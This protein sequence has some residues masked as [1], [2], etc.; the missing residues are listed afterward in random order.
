[1]ERRFLII[2]F[3]EINN[4]FMKNSKI[5]ITILAIFFN[6][7]LT[8]A[9]VGIGT[10]LPDATLDIV[11][12]TDGLLIPRISLTST[13][14]ALPLTL[15]TISELVYN[16][17]SVADVTPGY[18][19]W[20]GSKWVRLAA[21][22][23]NDW[24]V[25]GNTGIIDGTNFIGTAALTNVDVAFR[26]NNLSAGKIGL[27]STSFGVGALNVGASTNSSAF[28]T[29]ALILNTGANNVAFGNGT[30][31]A[32]TTG[33]QNTGV[34]NAALAANN[35]NAL[36]AIGFEALKANTTGI[37]GTAVGFQALS[38][39]IA[40]NNNTAIGFQ[41]LLNNTTGSENTATGFQASSLGASG[42]KNTSVGYIAL[43]NN[44]GS[45]N[46]AIDTVQ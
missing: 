21:G 28:G 5:I 8:K 1:M 25:L 2:T 29:N 38:R 31:S 16:V 4:F 45:E 17:A 27:T 6:V 13:T 14:S 44:I 39:N 3:F 26:R 11:S 33:I 40:A 46:T 34:G 19:Y 10:V 42:S 23:T 9:Q 18:Y 7:F 12:S 32:N 22:I 37:N 15:P 36:T 35:G 43:N 24:S 30:L 20:D 41:A